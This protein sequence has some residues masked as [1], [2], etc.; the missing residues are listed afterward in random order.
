MFWGCFATSGTVSLE[1]VHGL[2]KS[3]DYQ[4]S[5][6]QNVSLSVM[7]LGLRRT[8]WVFQQDN[9]PKHTSISIQQWFYRE[10]L[11]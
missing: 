2:M 6:E 5:L 9:D 7:K 4:E 1:C 10:R 3:G 8:S 11:F